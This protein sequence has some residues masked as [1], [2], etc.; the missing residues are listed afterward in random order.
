M[1]DLDMLRTMRAETP[2]PSQDALAHARTRLLDRTAARSRYDRPRLRAGWQTPAA[3]AAA[4]VLVLGVG[5]IVS[6]SG[7]AGG[8]GSPPDTAQSVL[9]RA[10]L[11]SRSRSP[12]SRP[13]ANTGTSKRNSR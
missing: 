1:N 4:A 10:A 11:V 7:P 3:T 13:K 8:S 2:Q 6:T 5:A 9:A 12:P